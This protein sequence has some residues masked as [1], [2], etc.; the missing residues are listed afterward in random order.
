MPDLHSVALTI[1]LKRMASKQLRRENIVILCEG[2][3]TEYQ[4]FCSIRDYLT[5][6]NSNR[7]ADIKVVPVESEM[8]IP[9]SKRKRRLLKPSTDGLDLSICYY[10]LQEESAQLYQAYSAYPTRFVRETKLYMDRYKYTTGWAVYDHDDHPDRANAA[11]LAD[12][13]GVKVAFSSR[14]FEQWLLS[15]FERN[16]T[17]FSTSVCKD[18]DG[19]DRL[20]GTGVA[21]DCHGMVCIGGRLRE[22]RYLPDYHKNQVSRIFEDYTLPRFSQCLVN[23]AWLN[24]LEAG[25][26]YYNRTRY[27][28]VGDLVLFLLNRNDR[29]E[30]RAMDEPFSFRGT[31]LCIKSDDNGIKLKNTGRNACVVRG[32]LTYCDSSVEP[33]SNALEVGMLSPEQEVTLN[34]VPEKA[35]FVCMQDG[36]RMVV[37]GL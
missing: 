17:I 14:C 34:P 2:T 10:C 9:P 7:F 29:V 20:C 11:K 18:E 15:H 3:K 35:T 4:Y 6:T 13:W 31:Q 16:S 27:T 25:T 1:F 37:V 23:V 33:L 19:R 28:N 5:K 22:M 32:L 21:N 8:V 36:Q 30:W 26:P 12:Q 24:L